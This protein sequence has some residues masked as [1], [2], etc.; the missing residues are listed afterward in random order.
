MLWSSNA[1]LDEDILTTVSFQEESRVKVLLKLNEVQEDEPR[2][3][4]KIKDSQT[5][6][7]RSNSQ[8]ENSLPAQNKMFH[9]DRIYELGGSNDET[10]QS[11]IDDGIIKLFDGYN[12]AIMTYGQS[13]TGK[14]RIMLGDNGD[15]GV[16]HD[17]CR[18]IFAPVDAGSQENIDYNISMNVLEV[19]CENVYDLLAP[20]SERKPLKLRWES[21]KTGLSIKDLRRVYVTNL[22]EALSYCDSGRSGDSS[23][24]SIIIRIN[25]EQRDT[26]KD[27]LKISSFQL[28]DLGSSDK[29][30]KHNSSGISSEDVKKINQSMDTLENVV[31]SLGGSKLSVK[32]IKSHPSHY[33]IPY[34][35]SYLTQLLRDVIGGNCITTLV[36]TCSTAEK[37]EEE[38]L[39]TLN[40]GADMKLVRNYPQPN[41]FGLNSRAK[42]DLL[43]EDFDVKEQN[44]LARIRLLEEEV[45]NLRRPQT[46]HR[47]L[48][49]RSGLEQEN[50][51][52]KAQ[53]DSLSQLLQ[54]TNISSLPDQETVHE[55]SQLMKTLMEK[56][57]KVIELQMKFD[58]ESSLNKSLIS[59]LEFKS[60]KEA[61]LEAM[62]MKLLEQLQSNEEELKEL[63]DSSSLMRKDVEKWSSLAGTR[64]EKIEDLENIMKGLYIAKQ[65]NRASRRLSASSAGSIKSQFDESSQ[66]GK[67]SWFFKSP[68]NSAK[69]TR[70]VSVN[71]VS[72][73]ASEESFKMK[74]PRMGGLNLHAVRINE[75]TNDS[76]SL[77]SN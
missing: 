60:S 24:S 12:I 18:Q 32:N 54:N 62:N 38:T 59:Q 19:R 26:A 76:D 73:R 29:L 21:K 56:C 11:I 68:S 42:I 49:N 22:S 36:L 14:T 13:K 53:L 34:K 66:S 39:K 69:A 50:N 40:F 31:R 28:I 7:L 45:E 70:K 8:D 17:V 61:A 35:E 74:G 67:L 52:L 71:S 48:Q 16:I 58:N 15:D 30:E 37:D 1:V 5:V 43:V 65:D 64:Y 2:L 3:P 77:E 23:R 57:E 41:K 10:K 25:L 47:A 4:Y 55:H 75:A 72:S 33:N 20:T 6:V 51:K 9:L 27:I 44:Y 63:L 46:E